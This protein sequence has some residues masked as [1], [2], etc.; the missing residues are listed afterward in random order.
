MTLVEKKGGP[1]TRDQ[2]EKRKNEVFRL[3]FEYGYSA[4]VIAEMMKINRNTINND[5][6]YWYSRLYKEWDSYSVDTW[7][8]K[9]LHRLESQRARLVK[10]LEMETKILTKL[11]IEKLILDV[12]TR[13]MSFVTKMK[14]VE[15]DAQELASNKINEWSKDHN[16]D[17][18]TWNI[19]DYV[20]ATEKTK[21]KIQK[22]MDEDIEKRSRGM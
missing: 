16:V 5:I 22:L 9:Q 1:Y 13:M 10:D 4:V 15:A 20:Y 17:L 8:M 14:S 7:C 6:S 3:H 19:K 12:D 11:A 2:K 18:R 21:E